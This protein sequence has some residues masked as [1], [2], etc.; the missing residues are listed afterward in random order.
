MDILERNLNFAA[1][2]MWTILVSKNN[3]TLMKGQGVCN[4][5]IFVVIISS[6]FPVY[7]YEAFSALNATKCALKWT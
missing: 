5:V 3:K 2:G 1:N 4:V 6:S 7:I